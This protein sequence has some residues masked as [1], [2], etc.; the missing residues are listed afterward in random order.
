MTVIVD[1]KDSDSLC[2]MIR[3]YLEYYTVRTFSLALLRK[4]AVTMSTFHS[5]SRL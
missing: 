4:L 1:M 3:P 5:F 2:S